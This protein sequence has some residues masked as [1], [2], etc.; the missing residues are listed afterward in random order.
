MAATLVPIVAVGWLT[1]R[2]IQQERGLEAQRAAENLR[3]AAGRLA[4]AV[5]SKLASI[6]E[7][8]AQGHGIRFGPEGLEPHGDAAVLY[9]PGPLRSAA[10]P[11]A[12]FAAAE[13]L[14]FQHKDLTAAS[15]EYRRLAESG[16]R[17]VRATALV[18]LGAA[19]RKQGDAI[20]ALQA[21]ARLQELGAVL[22]EDQPA[23]LIAR[24]ARCRL[25][26]S[27]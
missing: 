22:V 16:D 20:A 13:A 18:R 15:K 19:L 17:I 27:R 11:V 23:E 25:K 9:Q 6:E 24:Q 12:T 5:N 8:L 3:Y 26:R 14:E 2:I 7:Q 4:L 1:A 21:Y 10:L